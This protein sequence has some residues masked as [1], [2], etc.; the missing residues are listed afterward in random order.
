MKLLIFVGAVSAMISGVLF[1]AGLLWTLGRYLWLLRP[2]KVSLVTIG[3]LFYAVTEKLDHL[4]LKLF[5]HADPH[6]YGNDF[7]AS[8]VAAFLMW[9]GSIAA[10]GLLLF[11]VSGMF[12]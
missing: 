5:N 6:N 4:I 9:T 10:V 11:L 2:I 8:S 3:E 7:D 12:V 1:I